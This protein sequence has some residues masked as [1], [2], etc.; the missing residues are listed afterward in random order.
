[1]HS[2]RFAQAHN[3]SSENFGVLHIMCELH[4]LGST[5]PELSVRANNV[6]SAFT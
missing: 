4:V 2:C 5:Q 6:Q 3:V 1:M